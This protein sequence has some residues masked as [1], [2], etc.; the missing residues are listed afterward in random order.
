MESTIVSSGV[1]YLFSIFSNSNRDNLTCGPLLEEIS[2][3][4]FD[5]NNISLLGSSFSYEILKALK[6]MIPPKIDGPNG[7][8]TDFHIKY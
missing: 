5:E 2:S 6:G 1:Y 4:I 7:S 3:L 8:P